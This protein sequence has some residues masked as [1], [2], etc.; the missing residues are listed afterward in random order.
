MIILPI[1]DTSKART[2]LEEAINDK[3]TITMLVFGDGQGEDQIASKA[4]VRANALPSTRRVVWVRDTS[5][6]TRN[7][8]TAY[9]KDDNDIIVCALDL[10]DKPAVHLNR[11]KAKSFIHL[12]KAFL[13]AQQS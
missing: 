6:L 2:L 11:I 4:D 9:R 13:K 3:F 7:E 10:D 8:K 5:I 12:E 1:N